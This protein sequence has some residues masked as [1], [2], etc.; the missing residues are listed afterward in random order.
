M[1]GK[2]T[3]RW[4]PADEAKLVE[5]AERK[6]RIMSENERPVIELVDKHLYSFGGDAEALAEALIVHADELRDALEPF[7][8]GRRDAAAPTP[9]K[10]EN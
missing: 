5:L 10:K 3:S 8:S 2:V 7:D 9:I 6:A 1:N 4:T